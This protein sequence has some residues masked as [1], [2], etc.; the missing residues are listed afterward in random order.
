MYFYITKILILIFIFIFIFIIFAL[1][2]YFDFDFFIH[3]FHTLISCVLSAPLESTCSAQS[4]VHI[5]PITRTL[6]TFTDKDKESKKRRGKGR[7]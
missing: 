1:I 5:S 7:K 3:H 4:T 6:I 2:F